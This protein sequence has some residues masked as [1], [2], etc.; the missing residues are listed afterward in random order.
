MGRLSRFLS[1]PIGDKFRLGLAVILLLLVRVGVFVVPFATFRSALVAL[2]SSVGRLVP[3]HPTPYQVAWAVDRADSAVPGHRT[4][5][6]RSLTSETIHVLYGHDVVHRIGVATAEDDDTDDI[7]GT[8]ATGNTD[9]T[10]ST[11]STDSTDDCDGDS[12]ATRDDGRRI[13]SPPHSDPAPASTSVAVPASTGG[14]EA[15][16]WIEYDGDVILGYL[17]DLSRFEPLPPLNE[18]DRS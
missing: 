10:D 18:T 9:A 16:S 2:T 14:F 1:V 12:N 11:D 3:G 8:D 17:E 4:C 13:G 15:H 6:M 7:D 5:L